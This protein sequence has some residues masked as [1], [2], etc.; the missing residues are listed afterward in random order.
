MHIL[1]WI[2]GIIILLAALISPL[3]TP[4]YGGI[5]ILLIIVGFIIKRRKD[6]SEHSD[7]DTNA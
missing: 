6:K 3:N 1:F 2:V 5:G 7:D 4:L